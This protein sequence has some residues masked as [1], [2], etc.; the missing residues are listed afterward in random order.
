LEKKISLSNN[1]F[2]LLTIVSIW[3]IIFVY[4]FPKV[5]QITD[6]NNYIKIFSGT[7]EDTGFYP[8]FIIFKEI[9]RLTN[10][11]YTFFQIFNASLYSFSTLFIYYKSSLSPRVR[12]KNKIILD[13]VILLS[14]FT[15]FYFFKSFNLIKVTLAI[16][17]LNISITLFNK[18]SFKYY[19]FNALSILISPLAFFSNIFIFS[20]YFIKIRNYFFRFIISLELKLKIVRIKFNLKTLLIVLTTFLILFI[21]YELLK[22]SPAIDYE[23]NAL[24]ID[25]LLESFNEKISAYKIIIPSI[26]TFFL[27]IIIT[28]LISIF[29]PLDIIIWSVIIVLSTVFLSGRLTIFMPIYIY[30]INNKYLNLKYILLI[31]FYTYSIFKGLTNYNL[32]T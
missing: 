8:L 25:T 24:L 7:A 16:S 29:I 23:Q 2:I 11:N 32:I 17:W 27:I 15:S 20:D 13:I 9:Y 22:R 31:S 26:F 10:F 4:L 19:I 3:P 5:L 1:K 14:T 21:C 30:L 6:Y 28:S 18:N 12:I